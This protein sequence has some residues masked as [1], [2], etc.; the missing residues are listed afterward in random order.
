MFVSQSGSTCC[1]NEHSNP[2]APMWLGLDFHD[3][4][5]VGEWIGKVTPRSVTISTFLYTCDKRAWPRFVTIACLA[6]HAL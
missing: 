4:R 1:L 6:M 2:I 5:Y 3:E